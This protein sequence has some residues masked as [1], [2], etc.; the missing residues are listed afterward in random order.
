MP[1]VTVFCD[2]AAEGS[3]VS[4]TS[5][6]ISNARG[7]A[8]SDGCAEAVLAPAA[9]IR[10]AT[11]ERGTIREFIFGLRSHELELKKD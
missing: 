11:S 2:T 4:G 5:L 10:R 1:G 8:E 9:I 6:V 3:C 7:A